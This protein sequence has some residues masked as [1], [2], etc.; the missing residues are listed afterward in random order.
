MIFLFLRLLN[1]NILK[2][3]LEILHTSACEESLNLIINEYSDVVRN[4]ENLEVTDKS[5]LIISFITA[6]K[7]IELWEEQMRNQN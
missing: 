2:L 1:A 6:K 7:S 4:S 5:A 3:F